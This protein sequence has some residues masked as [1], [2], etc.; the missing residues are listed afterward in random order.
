MCAS[1]AQTPRVPFPQSLGGALSFTQPAPSHTKLLFETS[2]SCLNAALFLH[3]LPT[4]FCLSLHSQQFVNIYCL[5]SVID[6]MNWFHRG[7]G[8]K[9]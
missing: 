9:G 1:I 5:L 8:K 4:L 6:R 7:R 2:H 3:T